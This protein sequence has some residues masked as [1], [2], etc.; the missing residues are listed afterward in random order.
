MKW[1][2]KLERRFGRSGIQRLMLYISGLMLVVYLIDLFMPELAFSS[3]LYLAMHLVAQG[4][5]WRLF[6]FAI[7]PPSSSPLFVVISLYFYCM[8]GDALEAQWGSFRFN[9][10]YLCGMLGTILAGCITGTGVNQYLNLSL[11][12]AFAMLYPDFELLLFFFLPVKVKYLAFLDALY[13]LYALVM[14][15][16]ATKAAIVI[17]VLNILLFFGPDAMQRIKNH[18]AYRDSRK[19]F[20]QYQNKNRW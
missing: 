11:F 8:I 10:F 12:F 20:R 17:S 4:Q 6:T 1:L 13:F 19:T 2:N 16:W 7:L 9:I 14:G 15:S 3:Y 18:L 5:F